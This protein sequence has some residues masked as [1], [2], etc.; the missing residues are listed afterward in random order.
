VYDPQTGATKG[1]VSGYSNEKNAL[2][3]TGAIA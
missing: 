1:F 2:A 3:A